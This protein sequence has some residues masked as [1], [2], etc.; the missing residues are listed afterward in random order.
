M[1]SRRRFNGVDDASLD[2]ILHQTAYT[3]AIA[4]MAAMAA[5]LSST[6]MQD[7]GNKSC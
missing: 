6:G 2:Q 7:Y 5:V 3:V 4:V 1:D